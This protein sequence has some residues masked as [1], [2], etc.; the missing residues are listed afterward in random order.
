[1]KQSDDRRCGTQQDYQSR[2]GA[3]DGSGASS[4]HGAHGSSQPEVILTE[5][6]SVMNNLNKFKFIFSENNCLICLFSPQNKFLI[7]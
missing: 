1:M 2:D 6:V 5:E 7:F 4:S 3:H